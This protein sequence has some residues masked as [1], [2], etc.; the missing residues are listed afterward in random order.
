[1]TVVPA[2]G[3]ADGILALLAEPERRAELGRQGREHVAA[4]HSAAAML[5]GYEGL[6]R[7]L[8]GARGCT[9]LR[10]RPRLRAAWPLALMRTRHTGGAMKL[11]AAVT[12]HEAQAL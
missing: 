10:W 7:E 2:D 3:L 9:I 5:S 4:Q 6:Y 12:D 11:D 1:M 8:S